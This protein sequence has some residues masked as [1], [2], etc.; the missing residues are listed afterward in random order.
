MENIDG[1]GLTVELSGQRG[2]EYRTGFGGDIVQY[3]AFGRPL[4]LAIGG[5]IDPLGDALRFELSK[6]FLT[7]L[8][9]NGF[10]V[11][12]NEQGTYYDLTRPIGEDVFLKLRRASYD[13]GFGARVARLNSNGAVGVLGAEVMGENVNTA[14]EAVFMTDS[15]LVP[16]PGLPEVDNR[17][18]AFSVIRVGVFG[19][20]RALKFT[21]VRGFDAITA[22]QDVGRGVEFGLFAGPSIS[23]SQHT[24]DFFVSGELYAGLGNQESF[25]EMRFLGE[26]RVSRSTQRW[27]GVV[28]FGKLIWYVKPSA[29]ETRV[30]ALE[31]SQVQHL[32]F[33]LQLGFFDHEGGLLGY[34]DSRSAGGQRVILRLEE[35]HVVRLITSRADWAIAGFVATGK[36]WAGDVPYGQP[37]PVRASVGVSLL[38]AYPAGSKRTYRMDLAVPVNPD[39]AKFEI[40][41][42]LFD[43]TRRIWRQ[44]NDIAM[45]HSGAILQTLGSWI[46]R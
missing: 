7:D 41:F 31:L 22:A 2:F 44:P 36:I 32:V 14:Q 8:Q 16:A 40:R 19:G 28:G 30:M 6:P 24:S 42:S 17:Y 43:E 25:L 13:A 3:G 12:V 4:T 1:R 15:G 33:P 18:A 11:G 29:A 37:S 10:H 39:G 5:E 46:P 23:E 20:V 35:R 26:G 45:A 38:A 9:S 21:T 27:D 34:R